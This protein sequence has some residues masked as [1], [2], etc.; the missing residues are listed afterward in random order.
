VDYLDQLYQE[1][2]QQQS[3]QRLVAPWALDE[4][5]P[6]EYA[7]ILFPR[8]RG[9]DDNRS[10]VY[11]SAR[12]GFGQYLRRGTTFGKKLHL[13]DTNTIIEQLLEGFL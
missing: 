2:I 4:N 7:T 8:G 10:N 6:K 5:E 1:S 9:S 11:L 13:D 3:N 12:G